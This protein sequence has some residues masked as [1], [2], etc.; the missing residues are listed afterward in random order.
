MD[1]PYLPSMMDRIPL[2]PWAKINL[3]FLGWLAVTATWEELI[4]NAFDVPNPYHD[5]SSSMCPPPGLSHCTSSN[6]IS[7][8]H[9]A[10]PPTSSTLNF[11]CSRLLFPAPRSPFLGY[12]LPLYFLVGPFQADHNSYPL[13]SRTG[14]FLCPLFS[15]FHDTQYFAS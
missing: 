3:S 15:I 12:V 1:N 10:F 7:F 14:S 8:I 11:L 13:W 2:K 4:Q 6:S 9:S 5:T